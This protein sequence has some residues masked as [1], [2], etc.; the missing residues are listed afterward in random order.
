MTTRHSSPLRDCRL[1]CVNATST[2]SDGSAR[3][4]P[5]GTPPRGVCPLTDYVGM[6]HLDTSVLIR[7]LRPGSPEKRKLQRWFVDYGL[8]IA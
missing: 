4:P 2:S 3:A 7:A 6:I 1:P 8:T 5:S